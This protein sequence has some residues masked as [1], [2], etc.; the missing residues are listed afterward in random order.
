MPI[1]LIH[2]IKMSMLPILNLEGLRVHGTWTQKMCTDSRKLHVC[3][4]TEKYLR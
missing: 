4:E 2:V 1:T 3:N